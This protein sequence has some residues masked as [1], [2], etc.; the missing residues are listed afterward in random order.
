[1]DMRVLA[2]LLMSVSIYERAGMM[3]AMRWDLQGQVQR[4]HKAETQWK[5]QESKR[6]VVY[7]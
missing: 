1:M 7:N 5:A 3:A 6:A 4:Q 2:R